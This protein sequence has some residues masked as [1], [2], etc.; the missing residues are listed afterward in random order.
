MS[1]YRSQP[2]LEGALTVFQS[3]KQ[4]VRQEDFVTAE[5]KIAHFSTT[6][7]RD[8]QIESYKTG[9]KIYLI[10]NTGAVSVYNSDETQDGDSYNWVDQSTAAGQLVAREA[11]KIKSRDELIRVLRTKKAT[12]LAAGEPL[13]ASVLEIHLEITDGQISEPQ[14]YEGIDFYNV[15]S[16]ASHRSYLGVKDG[17]LYSFCS[18]EEDILTDY[19]KFNTEN[20]DTVD[21]VDGLKKTIVSRIID[22][23]VEEMRYGFGIGEEKDNLDSEILQKIQTLSDLEQKYLDQMDLDDFVPR[24]GSPELD[25]RNELYESALA[26]CEEKWDKEITALVE[27]ELVNLNLQLAG[28]STLS[29]SK[30]VAGPNVLDLPGIGVVPNAFIRRQI[31]DVTDETTVYLG[32]GGYFDNPTKMNLVDKVDDREIDDV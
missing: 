24:I 1:E 25:I 3:E 5:S 28:K 31:T 32:R 10:S 27:N 18:G 29:L 6:Y 26:Y 8:E 19:V 16:N 17:R 4:E 23:F 14:N 7:S 9:D 30:Q 21:A 2:N 20:L 12:E 13:L 11:K 15:G 22:L